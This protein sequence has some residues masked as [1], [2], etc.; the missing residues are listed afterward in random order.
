MRVLVTGGTGFIGTHLVKELI[1]NGHEEAVIDNRSNHYDKYPEVKHFPADIT[2]PLN[3]VFNKLAPECVI[4]LAAQVDVNQSLAK[5]VDD[6][7]TNIIGTINILEYCRKYHVS[8]VIYAS[9]AAVY[10]E[11]QYLGV[12]EEHPLIPL[13]F[14]GISKLSGEQYVK[15]FAEL[16]NFSYTIL[17]FANVYGPGDDKGESSVVSKFLRKMEMDQQPYVFGDGSQTRDFV[18]VKDVVS[19]IQSALKKGDNQIL[20]ISTNQQTS[21]KELVKKINTATGKSIDPIYTQGRIGEIQKSYLNNSKALTQ[22][23]WNIDYLLEDGL[24]EMLDRNT[25]K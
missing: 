3:E 2:K 17:R 9:S 12:D 11:P 16:Y 7:R 5:P 19:A 14:Y 13:S 1:A 15:T 24:I 22:L 23:D 21:L 25:S 18:Y 8:K 10:G 4:H 20:N 6:A